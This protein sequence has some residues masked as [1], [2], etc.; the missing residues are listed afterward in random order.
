MK[1][2]PASLPGV[3]AVRSSGPSGSLRAAPGTAEA[4]AAPGVHI[5]TTMPRGTYDFFTGSSMAAAQVSGVVA[6]LL[7]RA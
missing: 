3:L 7:W 2:F 6:L 1:D 4:L 5:L